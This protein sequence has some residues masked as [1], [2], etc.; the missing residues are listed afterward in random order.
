MK[1]IGE[2]RD[3]KSAIDKAR[4]AQ[5]S[6]DIVIR[7]LCGERGGRDFLW[8]ILEQGS[9]YSSAMRYDEQGRGDQ[10]RTAYAAGWHDLGALIMQEVMRADSAGYVRMLTENRN[11]EELE[12]LNARRSDTDN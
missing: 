12:R 8:W 6:R 1:D 2:E 5:D 3:V 4:S 10:M 9:P 11:V 7:V